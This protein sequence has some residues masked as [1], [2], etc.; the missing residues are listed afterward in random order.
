[1]D[2]M[3]AKN[4]PIKTSSAIVNENQIRNDIAV[5]KSSELEAKIKYAFIT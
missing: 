3:Q 4:A 2:H 1:M 5:E